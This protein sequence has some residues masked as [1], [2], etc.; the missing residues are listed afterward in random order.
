MASSNIGHGS[1]AYE[2][3]LSRFGGP[4]RLET[5]EVTVGTTAIELLINNPRR[6]FWQVMNRSLNPGSIGFNAGVTTTTGLYL[7][8]TGGYASM[9]VEDDGEVVTYPVY[10]I[11]TNPGSTFV[12]VEVMRV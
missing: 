2:F 11:A 9:S 7:G 1:T 10:G 5:R 12:I 4:T 8:P 3:S 6:V